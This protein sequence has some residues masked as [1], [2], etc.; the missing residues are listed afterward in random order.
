MK[1]RRHTSKTAAKRLV[2]EKKGLYLPVLI[3]ACGERQ[4][5]YEYRHG[6]VSYRA[7]TYSI[8]KNLRAAPTSSYS[9]IVARTTYTLKTL[10]YDQTPQLTG[11]TKIITAA[12][13]RTAG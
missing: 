3:E 2:K 7:F 4:L 9:Q 5:S 13:P 6:T 11:P 8:V 12:V 1:L 10:G